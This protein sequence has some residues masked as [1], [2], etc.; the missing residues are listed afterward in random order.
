MENK[1]DK[2][3]VQILTGNTFAKYT[4]LNILFLR[5]CMKIMIFKNLVNSTML[6]GMSPLFKISGL[7]R[8]I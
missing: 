1:T 8:F 6:L 3:L 7:E 5:M 4:F 2:F